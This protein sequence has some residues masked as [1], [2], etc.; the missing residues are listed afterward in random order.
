MLFE[1]I[2][3]MCGFN[4]GSILE[5]LNH[6]VGGI[7]IISIVISM[8][9]S[10]CVW[11]ELVFLF[12]AVVGLAICAW[13]CRSYL[14]WVCCQ[15]IMTWRAGAMR[16]LAGMWSMCDC[17][18]A[19]G[20]G[21]RDIALLR[22][23]EEIGHGIRGNVRELKLCTPCRGAGFGHAIGCVLRNGS[24]LQILSAC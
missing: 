21:L 9:G 22:A 8:H 7:I 3:G 14:T 23:K 4:D 20:A 2:S 16:A 5:K 12:G 19:L 18:C 15:S 24:S 1:M 11:I 10:V 6:V 13:V 17:R